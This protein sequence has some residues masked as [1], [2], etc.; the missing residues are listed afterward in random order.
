LLK[1]IGL[2]QLCNNELFIHM[3]DRYVNT[4]NI[5]NLLRSYNLM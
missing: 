3:V 4:M 2:T 5:V 1:P